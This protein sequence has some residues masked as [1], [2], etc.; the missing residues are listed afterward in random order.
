MIDT[1]AHIM[2]EYYENINKI[3]HDIKNKGV[4]AIINASDSINSAKE[5]IK[6]SKEYENYLLPCIGI[7]PESV[8]EI[9]KLD[10]LEELIKNNKIYAIGEIG[11]DYYYVK[12][13]KKEQIE[14]FNR[15]LDLAE[16]YNL[17]IVVHSRDSIQDIYD[18]LKNRKLKG[19]I[20]CFNG[21][22]EMANLFIKIGYKLGIGGVLTFKNSKL[23]E[24]IEKIDLENIV[25]ETDSP[26]LSPEPFRGQKNDP[27]N[28]YYVAKKIAEIKNINVEKVIEITSKNAIQTFDIK[29]YL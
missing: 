24:L 7:H 16:K 29:A 4:I 23:Y 27:S 15:Q 12:D 22:Y 26:Y 25:L 6:L 11:L 13:N 8:N 14:L 21:S 20:H 19:V 18:N 28:V 5:V 2:S 17:P 1:H 10:E 9:N 3:I